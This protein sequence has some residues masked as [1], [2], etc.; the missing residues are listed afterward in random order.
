MKLSQYYLG[1]LIPQM[2]H[3][4]CPE[5]KISYLTSSMCGEDLLD[6]VANKY[7]PPQKKKKSV[8]E[9][10]NQPL[11]IFRIV[12]YNNDIICNSTYL[13][14]K[15]CIRTNFIIGNYIFS[16]KGCYA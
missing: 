3:N 9:F 16:E 5:L 11:K 10:Y 15:I 8:S 12:S 4:K 2:R 1:R 7:V 6:S 13:Y 14:I